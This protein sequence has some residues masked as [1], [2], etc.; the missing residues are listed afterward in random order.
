MSRKLSRLALP[1]SW[2]IELRGHCNGMLG[3]RKQSAIDHDFLW[4]EGRED[5]GNELEKSALVGRLYE[6]VVCPRLLLSPITARLLLMLPATVEQYLGAKRAEA[7]GAGLLLEG[8]PDAACIGAALGAL[9]EEARYRTAAREFAGR[10][11]ATDTAQAVAAT[12]AQIEAALTAKSE[13]AQRRHLLEG[14]A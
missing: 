13:G 3:P 9:C 10:H 8:K 4:K 2:L 5:A 14:R 12:A 7:L 11:A 1:L 6:I